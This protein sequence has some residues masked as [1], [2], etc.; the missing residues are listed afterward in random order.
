L[1]RFESEEGGGAEG[2]KGRSAA[3]REQRKED[4]ASNVGGAVP[5]DSDQE[6]Q[7]EKDEIMQRMS[8]VQTRTDMEK[9]RQVARLKER[10]EL[11]KVQ[12][13]KSEKTATDLVNEA[14]DLEAMK[15]KDKERQEQ[16][17]KDRLEERKKKSGDR[18]TPFVVDL[19][20]P[21]T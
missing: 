11:K 18:G 19:T 3:G 4:M 13:A 21:S 20:K 1:V 14:S 7:D 5:Y 16:M 9:E 8:G 15:Q 12:H 10:K 17:I 6:Y 2:G